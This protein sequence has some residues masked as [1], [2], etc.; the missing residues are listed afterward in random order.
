M[1]ASIVL[2]SLFLAASPGAAVPVAV[3]SLM[4]PSGV[5][6]QYAE[7]GSAS[8]VPIIFLHGVTDSWRSFEPVFAHLPATVRAIAI[9]QRG[10]GESSRPAAGY[11]YSDMSEDLRAFMDALQIPSAVIVGHSMGGSVAQR[12]AVDHSGRVSALVLMGAFSTIYR[13]E[14]MEE[15]WR[16][17]LSKLADP[18]DP[19]FAREFQQSTLGR[20]IAPEWLETTVQ[21]SLKVPARVWQAAFRGFLDTPDFT[22]DLEKLTAPALIVWGDR[23]TY[24]TAADQARLR[25]VLRNARFLAYEGTGHAIHWEDPARF[26][27]D[28]LTFVA[29]RI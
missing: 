17:S 21:E 18:I 19:A 16:S 5:T 22:A 11:T 4:L 26:T 12:F 3:R 24:A 1:P 25:S 6:L 14:G 27:A 23:D 15:F 2:S 9:S 10:H 13:N 7:R 20:P 8:G 29:G 28:L